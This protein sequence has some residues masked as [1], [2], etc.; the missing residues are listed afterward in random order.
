MSNRIP[1]W[2]FDPHVFQ[3][4]TTPALGV[5]AM[6][7]S[8]L[9]SSVDSTYELLSVHIGSRPPLSCVSRGLHPDKNMR[10]CY[11]SLALPI[12]C[13]SPLQDPAVA[14]VC[15]LLPSVE[16]YAELLRAC[17]QCGGQP[18]RSGFGERATS[19]TVRMAQNT[20]RTHPINHSTS[21]T[22]YRHGHHTHGDRQ[23]HTHK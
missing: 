14:G 16:E 4:M 20:G 3:D 21:Y 7:S 1:D 2:I 6:T 22:H 12:H 11:S 9:D 23:T 13:I 5:L 19:L 17:G 18:R 8:S 15:F 10:L